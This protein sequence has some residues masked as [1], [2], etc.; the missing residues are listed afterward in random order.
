M[1]RKMRDFDAEEELNDFCRTFDDQGNGFISAF[2]L[3][4]KLNELK[5]R[6]IPSVITEIKEDGIN[7][8]F[9]LLLGAVNKRGIGSNAVE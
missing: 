7:G 6:L 3:R 8:S 2:E 1:A 4:E 9:S 5:G